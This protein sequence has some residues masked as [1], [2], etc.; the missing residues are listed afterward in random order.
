[1]GHALVSRTLDYLT[2]N[3][4]PHARKCSNIETNR[5]NDQTDQGKGQHPWFLQNFVF[6]LSKNF[7]NNTIA[8]SEILNSECTRNCLSA[9]LCP[10][11]MQA[12]NTAVLRSCGPKWIW[13]GVRETFVEGRHI[14]RKREKYEGMNRSEG[15][16]KE[17]FHTGTSFFALPVLCLCQWLKV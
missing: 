14:K 10:D 3:L 13:G 6:W 8:R 5:D 16:G 17:G 2:I 12:W 1:M 4:N 9:G 15:K 7:C 11:A